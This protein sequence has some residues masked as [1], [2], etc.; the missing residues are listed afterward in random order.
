MISEAGT[1][2]AGKKSLGIIRVS[3]NG[4]KDFWL[5]EKLM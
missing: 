4:L 3:L 2:I 1:K 5:L